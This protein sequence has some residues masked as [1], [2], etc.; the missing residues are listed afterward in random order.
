MGR[1]SQVCELKENTEQ[2]RGREVP[3]PM[4]TTSMKPYMP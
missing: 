2:V 1:E 3:S 4:Q